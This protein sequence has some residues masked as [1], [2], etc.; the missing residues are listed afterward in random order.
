MRAFISHAK[1][2]ILTNELSSLPERLF[3]SVFL[4]LILF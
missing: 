4:F 2:G 3:M 1:K